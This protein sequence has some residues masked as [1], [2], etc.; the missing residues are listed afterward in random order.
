MASAWPWLD[1]IAD[2]LVVVVGSVVVLFLFAILARITASFTRRWWIAALLLVALSV[3]GALVETRDV[4]GA[5]FRGL[6]AGLA[7]FLFLWLV[8]RYDLRTVPA[9]V[10][11]AVLLDAAHDAAQAGG[12]N[13]WV[14]FALTAAVA[15]A[16]AWATTRYIGTQLTSSEIRAS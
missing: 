3:A 9:Y 6:G 5:V 15:I 16:A 10:T 14:L 7:T 1:A 8:M 4:T 2:G 13:A 12:G 11:T